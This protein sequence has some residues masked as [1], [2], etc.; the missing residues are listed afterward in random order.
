MQA[1]Q[2]LGALSA[3]RSLD[4]T[5]RSIMRGAETV[6]AVMALGLFMAGTRASAQ[7]LPQ[8]ANTATYPALDIYMPFVRDGNALDQ[9]ILDALAEMVPL[10]RHIRH[11]RHHR[12]G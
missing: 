7:D 9:K 8:A 5:W 6:M 12:P 4:G 2:A 1:K 11:L 3:V 10:H